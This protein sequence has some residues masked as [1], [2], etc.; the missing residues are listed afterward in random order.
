MR[1]RSAMAATLLALIAALCLPLGA[2]VD[3]S[4]ATLKGTVVDPQELVVTGAR[5][6]LR[7]PDTGWTKVLQ[8]GADGGYRFAS[9]PPGSYEIRVEAR[10]FATVLATVSIS[11]G[12]NVNYD[13]GLR[14]GSTHE[15][16]EVAEVVPLIQVEQ[17]QQANTIGR[18]Q[19]AELPNL[20]HL[21]T[22]SIFTATGVSSSEAPRAQTPGFCGFQSTGFSIGGSN[23]RNNL[24]TMDGGENDL[25]SG[26]LRT[27][28]VP[29]E[30]VQEFQVN[31]SSFAAEF[32][33]TTGTA[34]NIVTRGGTNTWRGSAQ[35][36]F[37]D[38][39]TTGTNYFAPKMRAKA[40]AQDFVTGFTLGGPVI[41]NRLFVFTA[42]EFTKSDTPQFR[43]YANTDAARGIR[44][45]PAQQN[46]V[47]QLAQSGDPLLQVTAG[48]LQFLLDPANYPNTTEMLV[49]NSGVFNDWK[50][51][52]DWVTRLDY[53]PTVDDTVTGRFSLQHDDSSRMFMLDPSNA[54][55]DAILGFWRDYTL[56]S[57]WSHVFTPELLNQLRVQV[58]PASSLVSPPVSPH[59]AYIKIAGLGQ[60][61]GEHYEPFIVH[62]RR[63]Q[64]EDSFS[65]TR[66]KHTFKFGASYRPFTYAVHNE[67]MFGGD[68]QFWDGIVPILGG[69]I[70]A[71]SPAF[72][73]LV[74][75][76][77]AHG[78]PARGD[79]ATNLTALQAFDA[80]RPVAYVQA[81][82]N[83]EVTGWEHYFG[84]YAQD[85]WKIAHNL[86]LDLGV[87][88]DIDAP[89]SPMPRNAYFSPRLGFA[90]NPRG[91]Q[92]TVI[93]GGSGI[94]VAPIPFFFGYVANLMGDSGRYLNIV[95][96][97]LTLTDTRIVTLW[98]MLSG[99]QLQQ[100]YVCTQQPPFPRLDAADL[101]TAGI[102]I[103]P[104][105]PGRVIG[106]VADPYRNP[107]SV[108]TSLSVERQLGSNLALEVAYQMYHGVHLALPL[109]SNVQ[110]TGV[111]DPF[112]GPL[113]TRIDP[114]YASKG[115]A[116]S[117]GS[118]VYHGMLMS[119]SRRFA[120]GL[121]FQA[122]YTFSKT[123]DNT[124]D[125]NTEFKPFRP[126]R[127]SLERALSTFHI[128]H[129]FILNA[130]Y[131][132]PFKPRGSWLARVLADTTVSPILFLRSGIP[133]TIRVPGLQNGTTGASLWARPWHAGRNTGIGPNFYSL[134]LRLTKAFYFDREA[135][136]RLDLLVQGTNI[137]NRTN[138]SAVND[139]FP[140]GCM[141]PL[142]PEGCSPQP[143]Q[144]GPYMIDYLNGPFNFH[145][146]KGL[147][148]SSPLGFKAAFDPR[149]V[150]FGLKLI[151]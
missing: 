18:R 106:S 149:Q 26:Q 100:P 22:D 96:N 77:L 11:V 74:S 90:W 111:I 36:Y 63:F 92:K 101:Q 83:P 130:I 35:A 28:N 91:D 107:Y 119:L 135:G 66:G 56:V 142:P 116:S 20:S 136:R 123:L 144:V 134:D 115:R 1:R 44:A 139:S 82:G 131:A 146:V 98:A 132:T 70:P 127:L 47:N 73:A 40:F 81:F 117:A 12:E 141:L 8:T 151:F 120:H 150:Q 103:G 76:N 29:A 99:C 80:G 140:G 60:F 37:G 148:P 112:V 58:V 31:R 145:G 43:N 59:T 78:Q 49:S 87:R 21:F 62:Q 137:L 17:T 94:F 110:E 34:V 122:N 41:R 128:R 114:N 88:W 68:F 45:K 5:I 121:Q 27:P 109:E 33:F 143:F 32:G 14:V 39:H 89:S 113:Y 46:Y 133:F 95:A 48:Q 9:L 118:S 7:N 104:G 57:A 125:F 65:V 52:H 105:Q 10:G 53:Q 38:E 24:V 72:N 50:K 55:D 64:F 85:S 71:S 93:R 69:V 124:T 67:L 108:Q 19:I 3:Y 54:P 84:S 16:V 138:F 30:S 126:T 15:S 129:N 13:I 2:Q 4:T 79:P 86:T 23:G 42:Y 61:G 147:D 51:F 97:S 75:F 25:G 102:Q 6:S